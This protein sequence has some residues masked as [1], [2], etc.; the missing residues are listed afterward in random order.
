M[1]AYT[2]AYKYVCMHISEL[3]S[4]LQ[5]YLIQGKKSFTVKFMDK[6][7]VFYISTYACPEGLSGSVTYRQPVL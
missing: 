6:I 3:T 7:H 2:C 1:V 5:E 4:A